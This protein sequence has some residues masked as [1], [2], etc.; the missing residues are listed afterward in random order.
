[1]AIRWDKLSRF[2]GPV[3]LATLAQG[4]LTTGPPGEIQTLSLRKGRILFSKEF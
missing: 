4:S 3:R 2:G 1:M